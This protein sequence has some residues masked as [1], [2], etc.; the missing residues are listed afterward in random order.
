MVSYFK[1]KNSYS[2]EV[3][4][5]FYSSHMFRRLSVVLAPL[6]HVKYFSVTADEVTDPH[7]NQ[8][9]L[10]LC[11]RFVDVTDRKPQVRE[12]FLDFLHLQKA[13]VERIAEAILSLLDK[14]GLDVQD[15]RGHSY[16][17]ASAMA[18]YRRGAKAV[19]KEEKPL[20][21]YTY[22]GSHVLSLAIGKA[23]KLQ[24]LCNMIDVIN[25]YPS[26]QSTEVKRPIFPQFFLKT[27]IKGIKEKRKS[28][29]E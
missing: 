29:L 11:L 19:I 12:V 14:H 28:L 18:G 16:D 1:G 13:T 8:E 20:T 23:C 7:E 22:C 27:G 21:L 2:L 26:S 15:V 25:E 10:S 5:M 9:V 17:R 4:T 24:E 3:I 6:K